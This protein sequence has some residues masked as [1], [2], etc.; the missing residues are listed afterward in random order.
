MRRPEI[1]VRYKKV[2]TVLVIIHNLNDSYCVLQYWIV[3][4]DVLQNYR[5]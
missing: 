4:Y 5:K 1:K 3:N 2:R